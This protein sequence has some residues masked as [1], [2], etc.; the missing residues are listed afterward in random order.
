MYVKPIEAYFLAF[1]NLLKSIFL[2]LF[3]KRLTKPFLSK[4]VKIFVRK[5]KLQRLNCDKTS[6]LLIWTKT[7]NFSNHFWS[8]KKNK[9]NNQALMFYF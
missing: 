2:A 8:F 9:N 3:L 4:Y 6:L 7:W 1:F 5:F